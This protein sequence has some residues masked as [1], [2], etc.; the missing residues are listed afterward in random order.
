MMTNGQVKQAFMAGKPGSSA[1]LTSTGNSILSYGWWEIAR[2]VG[3]T[4]VVRNG[5]S[6]SM[7]TA[8]KHRSGIVGVKAATETPSNQG[9]M[10]IH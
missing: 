7:T 10:N 8:S 9:A 4:I 6:Y 5:D 2:R 1:N 3:D